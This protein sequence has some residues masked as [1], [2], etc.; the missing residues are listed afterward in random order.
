MR[1]G[2]VLPIPE[3]DA[4]GPG[5]HAGSRIGAQRRRVYELR[6]PLAVPV[7]RGHNS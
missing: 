1:F 5:E 2:S 6:L 7:S 4:Q 3:K